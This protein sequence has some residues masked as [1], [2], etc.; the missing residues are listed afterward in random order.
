MIGYTRKS[1]DTPCPDDNVL[2][3]VLHGLICLVDEG[4][5]GFV[6][7]LNEMGS[8]HS[9]LYGDFLGEHSLDSDPNNYTQY[10]DLVNVCSGTATLNTKMNAVVKSGSV[11]SPGAKDVRAAISLPR[12]NDIHYYI[13]GDISPGALKGDPKWLV[14]FPNQI[15][16]IRIFEYLVPDFE[17]VQLQSGP[18]N[19]LWKCAPPVVVYDPVKKRRIN[20]AVLHIYNEPPEEMPHAKA[21]DHNLREFNRTLT[22][23]GADLT[24]QVPGRVQRA[25]GLDLLPGLLLEE[26]LALDRRSD[27]AV[28]LVKYLRTIFSNSEIEKFK[29]QLTADEKNRFSDCGKKFKDDGKPMK[30]SKTLARLLFCLNK[31]IAPSGTVGDPGVYETLGA[32]GGGSGSQVCGGANGI[33]GG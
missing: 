14:E 22:Y 1:S 17:Q 21:A 10:I 9:Y 33:I 32:G 16:G 28:T 11:P 13:K 15:S 2:Y 27:F 18:R 19:I 31:N 29:D 23:L 25:K 5:D 20:V 6:A 12:P 26:V 8:D 7:Y 30:I 3:V 24:L 4:Q